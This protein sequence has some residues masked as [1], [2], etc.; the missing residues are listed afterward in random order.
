[1]GSDARSNPADRAQGKFTGNDQFVHGHITAQDRA[2]EVQRASYRSTRRR[3]RAALSRFAGGRHIPA[4]ERASKA[5]GEE[6][7]MRVLAIV[8]ATS[9]GV[10]APG[11]GKAWAQSAVVTAGAGPACMGTEGTICGRETWIVTATAGLGPTDRFL[12][13]V[14]TSAFE[15]PKRGETPYYD[16]HPPVEVARVLHKTGRTMKYGAEFLYRAIWRARAPVSA[17]IGGGMGVRMLRHRATCSFGACNDP[18]PYAAVLRDERL[19]HSYVSAITGMDI[20][21]GQG[22]F[23]RG[24]LRLDDF[25]SEKGAAQ[26]SVELGY[27][28][29]VR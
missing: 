13:T 25:P 17:F 3:N 23:V 8:F 2:P 22:V 12:V 16:G 6:D 20:A 29:P 28:V 24:A 14:R 9:F 10:V 27:R 26:F 5:R 15:K 4:R 19:I 1:V 7:T 21:I 11:P 18:G